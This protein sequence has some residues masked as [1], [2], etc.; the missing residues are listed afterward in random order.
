MFGRAAAALP[1]ARTASWVSTGDRAFVS[2]D[3]RTTFELIYPVASFTSASPY[4]TALPRLG[5]ALAGQHVHGAPVRVTGATILAS[6]GRGPARVVATPDVTHIRYQ[7]KGRHPLV[8][9]NRGRDEEPA[10]A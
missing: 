6:G 3:G 1:G 2:A 8:L 4:A 7:I 10:T 5:K 9:D